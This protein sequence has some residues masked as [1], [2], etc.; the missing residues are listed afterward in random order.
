[1]GRLNLYLGKLA[2]GGVWGTQAEAETSL[3]S[4]YSDGNQG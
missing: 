3:E 1:M 2:L 4:P